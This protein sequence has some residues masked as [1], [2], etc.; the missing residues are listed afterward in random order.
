MSSIIAFVKNQTGATT[1]AIK[2][3]G[4]LWVLL[5]VALGV[6][7]YIALQQ[8]P[9]LVF[10]NLQVINAIVLA[11]LADRTLFSNTVA[12]DETLENSSLGPARILARAIVVLAVIAGLTLGI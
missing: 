12:V 11:Y 9:V 1:A 2:R 4:V 10:K 3:N 8:I 6:V 5:V 7:G